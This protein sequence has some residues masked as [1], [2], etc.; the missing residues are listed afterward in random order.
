[1]GAARLS[2]R[3]G[4]LPVI[5]VKHQQGILQQF[6]L[7][8][9]FSNLDLTDVAKAMELDKKVRYKTIRWVLLQNIGRTVIR[10]DVRQHDI[11][12]VLRELA[13]P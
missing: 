6:G 9:E 12:A 13:K 3:L 11:L 4:L 2:Q 8:V 7:P 5:A 10:G 1:M